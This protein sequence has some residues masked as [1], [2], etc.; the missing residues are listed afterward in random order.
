MRD[1]FVRELKEIKNKMMCGNDSP[2]VVS[3]WPLFDTMSYNRHCQSGKR[4]Q[5]CS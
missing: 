2:V 3:T 5:L 1:K 4:S